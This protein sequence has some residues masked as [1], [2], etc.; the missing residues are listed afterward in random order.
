MDRRKTDKLQ[1][2][3]EVSKFVVK[4]DLEKS[5]AIY[6]YLKFYFSGKVHK[7]VAVFQSI[8]KCLVIQDKRTYQK[9]FQKLLDLKW[10]CLSETSGFYFIHS[11]DRIRAENEFKN[12]QATTCYYKHLKRLRAFLVGSILGAAVNGQKYYWEIVQKRKLK[13]VANKRDAT[14]PA[15][16]YVDHPKPSYFGL[17]LP[18]IASLLGC[19]KTRASQLRQEAT[20]ARF[21]KTRHRFIEIARLP[22]PDRNIRH[23]LN[24]LYP[25]LNGKIRFSIIGYK[26]LV[27]ILVLVQSH[28]EIIPKLQFKTVSKFNNLVVAPQLRSSVAKRHSDTRIAA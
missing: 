3:I 25:K 1:I 18:Q 6:L 9:H 23:F 10:I 28:D 20:K 27:T 11:F 2:P 15:K 5:F 12:R 24:E 21:I 14:S 16:A 19:K 7:D 13:P 26:G 4:N 22:K 17:S 8:K